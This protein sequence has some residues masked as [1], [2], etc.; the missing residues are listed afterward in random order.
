M[1]NSSYTASVDLVAGETSRIEWRVV[2]QACDGAEETITGGQDYTQDPPDTPVDPGGQAGLFQVDHEVA[3]ISAGSILSGHNEIPAEAERLTET[4]STEDKLPLNQTRS[5]R[6]EAGIVRTDLPVGAFIAIQFEPP[7]APGVWE[8]LDGTSGPRLP[9][10]QASLEELDEAAGTAGPWVVTGDWTLLI[11]EAK[12][13]CRFRAVLYG[14]DADAAKIIIFS[15]LK[16]Q[17]TIAAA[18]VPPETPDDD[19]T[20]PGSCTAPSPLDNFGY[21]NVAALQSAWPET[22]PS[23]V[24][25]TWTVAANVVTLSLSGASS[26]EVRRTRTFEGFDPDQE[27]TFYL[28]V[29]QSAEEL[30]AFLEAEGETSE[31][32]DATTD[33][34]VERLKVTVYPTTDGEV[35]LRWGIRDAGGGPASSGS[36]TLQYINQAA[37]EAAGWAFA[38]DGSVT[39]GARAI[40]PYVNSI[41]LRGPDGGAGFTM[42]KTY[43]VTPGA[44][45]T[46]SAWMGVDNPGTPWWAPQVLRAT[47]GVNTGSIDVNGG[48]ADVFQGFTIVAGA[49]TLVVEFE[50]IPVFGDGTLYIAGLEIDGLGSSATA[51]FSDLGFCEGSGMP[52]EGEEEPSEPLPPTGPFPGPPE[53]GARNFGNSR[54]PA[55]GFTYWNSTQVHLTPRSTVNFLREAAA[56]GTYL[57]CTF[58]PESDWLVGGRFSYEAWKSTVDAVYNDPAS[59]AAIEA[60]LNVAA[61]CLYLIDEPFHPTRYGGPIS[62]ATLFRMFAYVKSLWPTWRTLMRVDPTD[63]RLTS[64]P[65]GC[66]TLW[67]EYHLQRGN[68]DTYISTRIA[69]AQRLDVDLI[70]G[71][72]YYDFGGVQSDRMITAAELDFYGMKL[73]STSFTVATFGWNYRDGMIN[74]PGFL[75]TLRR[76]RDNYASY[77]P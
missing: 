29:T 9:L 31:S 23:T 27:A 74:Q 5:A 12:E 65:P 6:V 19:P 62:L 3:F 70:F 35:T 69:A 73:T 1:S 33:G 34:D 71:L 26:G 45:Y 67:A 37:A 30:Q 49:S 77:D 10:D 21:A 40:G 14:G 76:V 52:E 7:G 43:N 41:K 22:N 20:N 51:T 39:F 68:I 72:H 48:E 50:S 8:Y 75:D 18:D 57:Y 66:D 28:N 56:A 46:V 25:N 61:W 58:G 17:F 4:R 63:S 55:A 47:S 53:G 24:A 60:N 2:Y 13:D 42:T 38:G 15:H 36:D 44:T 59:N 54:L 16:V 32:D 64:L 11:D